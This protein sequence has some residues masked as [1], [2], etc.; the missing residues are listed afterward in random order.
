MRRLGSAEADKNLQKYGKVLLT[1]LPEKTTQLLV[2]LCSGVL[3]K[4]GSVAPTPGTVTPVGAQ[5]G[6]NN[7]PLAAGGGPGSP[8]PSV[9]GVASPRV[10][11]QTVFQ[12]KARGGHGDSVKYSPPSPR[13]FMSLF[14]DLPSYLITFLEQVSANR[15]PSPST[16][17]NLT[18][19]GAS[20]K[21]PTN[22]SAARPNSIGSTNTSTGAKKGHDPVDR[23]SLKGG[24][25]SDQDM[26]ERKAVWNTLFELYLANNNT[27]KESTLGAADLNKKMRDRNINKEKC[28]RLLN[29]SDISYDMNHALVLCHLAEFVEGIVFLYE[30][31]K[32]YTDI[33]RLWIDKDETSKVIECLRK[34]G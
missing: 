27:G 29:D 7:L 6:L 17:T 16:Q 3:A 2:D 5:P 18:P 22:P 25:M 14:V 12:P 26:E 9:N 33:L 23:S 21:S 20:L 15:W 1:H 28:L 31:M 8:N 34:Y 24:F 30:R 32:M 19:A 4:V 11:S 10:I 13:T